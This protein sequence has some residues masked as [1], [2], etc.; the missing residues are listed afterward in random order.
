MNGTKL[1]VGIIGMGSYAASQHVPNLRATGRAEVT[2]AARRNPERL[3]LLQRE[4]RIPQ[5]F[6][7]WREML[8]RSELDAVVVST[9]HNLRVEPVLAALERGLHVLIEKP[10]ATTVAD[11]RAI[12]Q[13][14]HRSDRV[15][16]VGLNRRGDPSWQAAQRVVAA[17][18]IGRVRQISAVKCEDMRIWREDIPIAQGL[19][20][21]IEASERG[22]AF[23]LDRRQASYWRRDPLQ[24]GGDMFADSGVHH[25]DAM[26][27]LAGAPAREVL[28]YAPR[29][30]PP[31]AAIL[32]LQARLA[33]EAILSLTYNDNVALADDFAFRG[34]GRLTVYGDAGTLSLDMPGV[35]NGP[36]E[37]LLLEKNGAKQPVTVEGA[38]TSPAA[39]FVACILDG[40]PNIAT[41]DDG[42]N[43]VALIE[44]TYRSIAEG[45]I[46]SV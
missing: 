34:S 36:A 15:V 5:V 42:A 10:L 38:R 12:V 24:L 17:G 28:A 32:T 20:Q 7:D 41:V 31:M 21:R 25:V 13:A 9:P 26:L 4:L 43:V 23:E 11:A 3:A 44:G 16:M 39:A 27:W 18:Q 40:A 35:G 30:R 29:S 22:K 2:A 8:A 14:A 33:N 6:T 46:V 37:G 45:R 19:R 1:R